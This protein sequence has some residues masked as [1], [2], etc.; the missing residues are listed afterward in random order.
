MGSCVTLVSDWNDGGEAAKGQLGPCGKGHYERVLHHLVKDR[1]EPDA[2]LP[3]MRYNLIPM[4]GA[5]KT[6]RQE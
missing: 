4:P 5:T 3:R 6:C 1:N 2:W